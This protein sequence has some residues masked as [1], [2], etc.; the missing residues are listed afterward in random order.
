MQDACVD[1]MNICQLTLPLKDGY[2]ATG[3]RVPG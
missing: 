1:R 3:G 2:F